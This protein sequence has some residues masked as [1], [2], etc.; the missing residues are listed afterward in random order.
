MASLSAADGGGSTQVVDVDSFGG[1][2]GQG[3]RGGVGRAVLIAERD[4][5]FHAGGSYPG[6]REPPTAD[7]GGPGD[8]VATGKALG[9]L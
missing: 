1:P 6:G 4:A 2:G 8:G 3:L 9:N 7:C 5:N